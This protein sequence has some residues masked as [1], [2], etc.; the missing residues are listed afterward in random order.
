MHD[1]IKEGDRENKYRWKKG[2]V[3]EKYGKEVSSTKGKGTYN[4]QKKT[5]AGVGFIGAVSLYYK[6]TDRLHIMAEPY[7]RYNF[8]PMNKETITLKQK[9][10]TAGL[11][12]GIRLDLK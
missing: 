11:R 10:Q 12:L 5:N 6:L 4:Y 1:N 3:L 7:F 2:D 8:S 9:Y